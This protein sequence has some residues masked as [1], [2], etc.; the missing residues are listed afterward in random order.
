VF[1]IVNSAAGLSRAVVAA[2]AAAVLAAGYRLA[3]RQPLQQAVTGLLSVAVAALIAARSGQARDYFVLGI[4]TA[5]GYGA[6]LAV[7][8]LVRRPLVG[9]AWEFLDPTPLPDGQR[10]FRVRPLLRAYDLA[11]LVAVLVFLARA[12]VQLT[13]FREHRTGWLAVAKLAMGYPLYAVA[14]LFAVWLVRR[15]RA[16][17]PTQVPPDPES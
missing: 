1:V 2:I 8:L 16:G 11:T 7:S 5:F 17:L 3:R 4:I 14:V 9:V 12:V 13:L 10:W 6:V 15:C